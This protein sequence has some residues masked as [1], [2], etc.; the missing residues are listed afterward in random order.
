ML[1]SFIFP[2]LDQ[3]LT[4]YGLISYFDAMI[5]EIIMGQPTSSLTLLPTFYIC[6]YL[7]LELVQ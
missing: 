2:T 3:I 1:I 6:T 5:I 7:N 4:L